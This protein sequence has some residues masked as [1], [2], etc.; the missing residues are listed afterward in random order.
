MLIMESQ[1]DSVA[2]RAGGFLMNPLVWATMAVSFLAL[3]TGLAERVVVLVEDLRT[4]RL[5]GSNKPLRQVP[6]S[7][8]RHRTGAHNP[9]LGS[10]GAGSE[11]P[12]IVRQAA[13][14]TA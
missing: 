4:T 10:S 13:P 7:S 11:K 5:Q 9:T 1:I 8:A 12:L 3:M 6:T 2:V 14:E